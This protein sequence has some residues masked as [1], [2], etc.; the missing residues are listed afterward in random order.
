MTKMS[1]FGI[2]TRASPGD[3]PSPDHRGDGARVE[4]PQVCGLLHRPTSGDVLLGGRDVEQELA[5]GS[6]DPT[7]DLL[8]LVLM[9]RE[10]SCTKLRGWNAKRQVIRSMGGAGT[11]FVVGQYI[12]NAIKGK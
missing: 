6:H 8:V 12:S 7:T 11:C 9:G 5:Q 3:A 2:Q 10:R 1:A 4:P